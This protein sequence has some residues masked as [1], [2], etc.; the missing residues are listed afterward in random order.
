MDIL[1]NSYLCFCRLSNGSVS[2]R[3]RCENRLGDDWTGCH[4]M[5][6]F[7]YGLFLNLDPVLVILHSV[8]NIPSSHFCHSSRAINTL[9]LCIKLMNDQKWILEGTIQLLR[10]LLEHGPEHNHSV[11]LVCFSSV[12]VSFSIVTLVCSSSVVVSFS[13]ITVCSSSLLVWFSSIILVCSSILLVCFSSVTYYVL[14]CSS[15]VALLCL[16]A[17]LHQFILACYYI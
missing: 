12:V 1:M 11:T 16:A 5:S 7:F 4:D 3:L 17:A 15:N 6:F 9:D 14:A 8:S 10:V 13:S 2:H